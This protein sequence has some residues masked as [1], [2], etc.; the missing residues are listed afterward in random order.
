MNMHRQKDKKHIHSLRASCECG[1]PFFCRNYCCPLK[2]EQR[3]KSSETPDFICFGHRKSYDKP[4]QSKSEG[5]MGGEAAR[6]SILLQSASGF[7]NSV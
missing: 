4:P 3:K 2:L 6:S 5:S 1:K 7:S